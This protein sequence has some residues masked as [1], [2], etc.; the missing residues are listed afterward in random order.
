MWCPSNKHAAAVL[1]AHIPAAAVAASPAVAAKVKATHV[2]HSPCNWNKR[3][4]TTHQGK[5]LRHCLQKF[6]R[7]N[8]PPHCLTPYLAAQISCGRIMHVSSVIAASPSCIPFSF[9]GHVASTNGSTPGTLG[10]QSH[11]LV[12]ATL[13]FDLEHFGTTARKLVKHSRTAP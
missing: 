11:L 7:H 2:E 10:R 12:A 9:Q 5:T 8:Q 1:Q 3:T 13:K 4:S 6:H